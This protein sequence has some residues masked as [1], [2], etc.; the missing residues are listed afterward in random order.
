M[1]G[2]RWRVFFC[3]SDFDTLDGEQETWDEGWGGGGLEHLGR[4]LTRLER[5]AGLGD[6]ENESM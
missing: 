1:F 2:L 3:S 6:N 5:L 4:K